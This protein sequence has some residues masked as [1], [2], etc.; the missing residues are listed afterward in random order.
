V[1]NTGNL[2]CRGCLYLFSR[3][4]TAGG[5]G[6]CF[7]GRRGYQRSSDG[8][9][10]VQMT[11]TTDRLRQLFPRASKAFLEANAQDSSPRL[12]DAERKPDSAPPLAGRVPGKAKGAKRPCLR[13]TRCAVRL[14][15]QDNL[16]GGAKSLIDCIKS[17]GLIEDDSPGC[18]DL[19]VEQRQVVSRTEERTEIELIYGNRHA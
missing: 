6:I 17:A 11:F 14:L 18:V 4:I 9:S 1:L 2:F 10:D 16:V 15:D 12:P 3:D 19:H 8:V 7:D 13:I 5:G